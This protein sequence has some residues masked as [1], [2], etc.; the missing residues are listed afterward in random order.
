MKDYYA[1][2]KIGR[3]IVAK[4]R[5]REKT[6]AAERDHGKCVVKMYR[7]N[8]TCNRLVLQTRTAIRQNVC[9]NTTQLILKTPT[10]MVTPRRYISVIKM[11]GSH[12]YTTHSA[13]ESK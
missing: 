5:D 7:P 9:L 3:N 11:A 12:T 2:T 8:S 13:K 4:E 1:F 10:E 6:L